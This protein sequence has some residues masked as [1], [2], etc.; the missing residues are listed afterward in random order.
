MADIEAS[1]ATE[2]CGVRFPSAVFNAAGAKDVSLEDLDAL[3]QSEAGAIVI[4]TATKEF[5]AGNDLPRWHADG[6]G[7]LN[8]MGLPNL[9]YERY[10]ASVPQLKEHGKPVIASVSGIGEGDNELMLA[11]YDKAGVDMVE[12]N[13][14]CPNIAGKGQLG[15]DYVASRRMLENCRRVTKLPMGVKL[16]PYFDRSQFEEMAAVLTE[17]GVDFV[18]TINSIGNALVIDPETEEKVIAPNGGLGG[19]GGGYVKPTALGNVHMFHQIL[20]GKLPIIGVVGVAAG[21]D[22]FEHLLAGASA[23]GVGTALVNEGPAVFMRLNAELRT[24][25]EEHGYADPASARGK[26][27]DKPGTSA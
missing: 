10:V 12:V 21:T 4:K 9:G 14:S 6:S 15:Y 24:V 23:V 2:I 22:A 19:L 17:T 18:V 7:S 16:P 3:G 26:L 1:I 25:L 11:A 27:K 20:G 5:R 13:L 8:S